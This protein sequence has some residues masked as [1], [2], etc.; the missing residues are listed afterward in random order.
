MPEDDLDKAQQHASQADLALVLGTS[1]LVTPAS[2]LPQKTLKNNGKLVIVNLQDTKYDKKCEIRFFAKIDR[3]MQLLMAELKLDVPFY[4]FTTK[5]I[6]V[7]NTTEILE[8][9]VSR[10]STKKKGVKKQ[11][12]ESDSHSATKRV[13][14]FIC[15]EF[16]Y[17][18]PLIS[19]LIVDTTG[20]EGFTM[21]NNGMLTD[22][23]I[24]CC[25]PLRT[26]GDIFYFDVK[27][28]RAQDLPR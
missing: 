8:E 6:M 3:V 1:L 25:S 9:K 11:D 14:I 7:G 16:G 26:Q 10:K 23:K 28:R 22:D 18:C 15:G 27:V 4:K 21:L 19:S 2:E 17:A 20:R 13:T 12:G 24:A 5:R